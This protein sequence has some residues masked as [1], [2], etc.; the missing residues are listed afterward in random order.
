M[1]QTGLPAWMEVFLRSLLSVRDRETVTGDL[2]EEFCDRRV[3]WQSPA[4]ASLWYLLQA[5]SFAPR[6][7]RSAFTQPR[8]LAALCIFTALC[9]CWLGAMDL[10]LRH[11]GYVGQIGIA[12]GILLQ[13]LVTLGSLRFRRISLLRKV[14]MFGSL[15]LFWLAG[16]ALIATVHGA[17]LEGYV[18]L[19]AVAL[20]YQ[21]LLT[22]CTVPRPSAPGRL[23]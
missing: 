9:G 17:E 23:V 8:T 3:S 6:R 12:A 4:R 10:R 18:L 21:A 19:I 16:K 14:S 1:K 2:Y 15:V 11:P 22:L 7:C 13:A 20:L 5:V